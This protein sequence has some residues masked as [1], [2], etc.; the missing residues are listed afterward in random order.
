LDLS[1]ETVFI[2]SLIQ[3]ILHNLRN[4][5]PQREIIFE[6]GNGIRQ[7]PSIQGDS[8]RLHQAL[9]NVISN[10]I[11]YTPDHGTITID[12][13]QLED[14]VHVW[15]KDTG[16]GIPPD[17]LSHIFKRFYVL[18]DVS[19]HRSSKTAFKGGG[20][21]L[22][23][24]VT[25]GIVEAHGGKIWAESKGYDEDELPGSTFHILLPMGESPMGKG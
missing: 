19:L 13:E 2:N 14:T 3:S 20:L 7:V 4:F 24:S 25:K 9:S 6:V 8:R 12:A 16:V 22:G 23:L 1:R 18:E 10:A 5:G 21:G 11:K 17:E 15:V